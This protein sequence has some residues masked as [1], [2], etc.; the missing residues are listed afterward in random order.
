MAVNCDS[1]LE[2]VRIEGDWDEVGSC[3]TTFLFSFLSLLSCCS[4][5]CDFIHTMH[6]G[7]DFGIQCADS[8]RAYSHRSYEF[9]VT[10]PISSLPVLVCSTLI[11]L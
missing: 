2:C 10:I 8:D 6:T 11:F 1:E 3:T 5:D 9:T 4:R 7:Y